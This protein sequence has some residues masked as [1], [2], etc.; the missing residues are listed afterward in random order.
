MKRGSLLFL[1]LIIISSIRAQ[2]ISY[3]PHWWVGMKWNKVQ[4]LFR[5]T[6]PFTSAAAK[7][8][9]KGVRIVK[10]QVLKI[11]ITSQLIYLSQRRPLLLL[12]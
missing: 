7:T 12:N 3:P 5:S 6:D 11:P 4:I 2:T 8:F 10:S 1:S 9:Y